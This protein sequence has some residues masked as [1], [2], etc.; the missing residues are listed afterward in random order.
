MNCSPEHFL[1]N[2]I[3]ANESAQVAPEVIDLIVAYAR[4]CLREGTEPKFYDENPALSTKKITLQSFIDK[5]QHLDRRSLSFLVSFAEMMRNKGLPFLFN[6]AH[7]ADFLDIKPD[8]LQKIIKEKDRR[9]H[10]FYIPKSNGGRRLISAPEGDLKVLQKNILRSILERVSLHPSANGFKRGRSILTNAEN[11]IGQEIVIKMDLMDFFPS[12][13]YQRVKGVYLNLGYPEGV[14]SALAEVSTYKGRLPMGA[15]T[16]PYLSNIVASRLDRRFTNLGKKMNFRYSRYA[17]DLAFSSQDDNFTQ[18]LSYF[19]K[20]IRDEGF[21]VNEKK[22]V[23]A[24][25]GG[26]QKITGVVVNK[27]I[28]VEKAEYKKLRAVVHNCLN[29]EVTV[30]MRKWGASRT[31]E[32]KNTLSGHINFVKMVNSEKGERLLQQFKRISWP[33]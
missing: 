27:K 9:Y 21:E 14:A 5:N 19:R 20:I 33:A 13:T 11:H 16:S 29:G 12:I 28:N 7:L 15:P 6:V 1:S 22:I 23:I 8:K 26:R 3:E 2:L 17:D 30:E 31:D 4:L 24:R 10:G 32:F 25:K 18:Q